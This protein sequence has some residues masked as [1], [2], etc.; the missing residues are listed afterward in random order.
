MAGTIVGHYFPHMLH[1]LLSVFG[2]VHVNEIDHNNSPHVA[3]AELAGDLIRS[4]QI[5][6]KRIGLLVVGGLRPVA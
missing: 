3:K 2:L 1:E 5:D 6:L 4:T